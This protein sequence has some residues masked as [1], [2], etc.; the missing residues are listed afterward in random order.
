[1]A[2]YQSV[3][4]IRDLTTVSV[5]AQQASYLPQGVQT[6]GSRKSSYALHF[7]TQSCLKCRKPL[8]STHVMGESLVHF[9][10]NNLFEPHLRHY[11]ILKVGGKRQWLHFNK[12]NLSTLIQSLTRAQWRNICKSSYDNPSAYPLQSAVPVCWQCEILKARTTHATSSP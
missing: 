10:Q 1:M 9:A 12:H 5:R 2:V 8:L 11:V 7:G 4:C 3:N 6:L